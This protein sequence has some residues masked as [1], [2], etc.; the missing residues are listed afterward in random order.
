MPGCLFPHLA[1][2]RHPDP[3]DY[4]QGKLRGGISGNLRLP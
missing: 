2:Q 4:A 3:F 1:V